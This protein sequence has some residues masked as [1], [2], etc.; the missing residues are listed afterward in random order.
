MAALSGKFKFVLFLLIVAGAAFAGFGAFRVGPEATVAFT[1]DLPGIG[2][3]TV[4]T[5]DIREPKRGLGQAHAVLKQGDRSWDLGR[6]DGGEMRPSWKFWG[7]RVEETRLE[8]PVGKAHQKEL[9]EGDAVIEVTVDRAGAWLRGPGPAVH[10]LTLPVRLKPPTISVESTAHYVQQG[11]AE[12]VVYRVGKGAVRDGVQAGDRFFPGFPL[13]GGGER[14]RFALFAG[15]HDL[16]DGE[17]VRL[18][19][20]DDIG[21][22]AQRAFV[23]RYKAR[24]LLL[25][26]ISVDDTFMARV[27][28][29]ILEQT[30]DLDDQGSLVENYVHINNELRK[31]NAATLQSLA[32]KTSRTFAWTRPF[33]SL[34]NA[35]VTSHFADRRTYVYEGREIDKQDHLGFDLASVRRAEI[36]AANRGT[37]LMAEYFG[38][39]GNTILIDHGYGLQSLY[40]H[41]SSISVNVGDT[42][43]RGQVIGRTGATGL[44]GGDHLHFTMLVHGASVDPREWWDGH[45]IQD[46]IAR[47]MGNAWAF[48]R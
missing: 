36:P 37:V 39:Y 17:R 30:P 40:G 6:F 9:K 24:P 34:P 38:I 19:A 47:K 21:N 31:Q 10:S 14:D 8:F 41:L 1:H 12:C 43:E 7:P 33:R 29:T 44:A 42:V 22:L 45:W 18:I 20:E 27:V 32:G 3:E 13:P 25:D 26:T 35:A 28:P 48:E 5:A 16:E 2:R 4:V 15:P 46:R 11:G 23:D